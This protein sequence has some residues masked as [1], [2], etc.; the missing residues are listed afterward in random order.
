MKV[1][2]FQRYHS[3]ENVATANTM[4]LLN[5]LYHYSSDK[6][7]RLLKS[8][9]LT[10]N[11]EPEI[12]FNIQEKGARSVP[13][14]A[15]TQKSFKILIE[16]KRGNKFDVNQLINHLSCFNNEDDKILIT[17]S[18]R[19]MDKDVKTKFEDELVKN[20]NVNHINTTFEKLI[21]AIQNNIDDIDYEMQEVLDDYLDY[22]LHD[23]LIVG[24]DSWKFMRVQRAGTTF[25]FNVKN[26]VYYD[27]ADHGFR[28]HDYL[29]LYNKKSVR[30]VGKIIT[31][32]TAICI[33]N[34]I[35]YEEEYG[36]LTDMMKE[37]IN[38]AM[39]DSKKYGYD[40]KNYKHRYFFVDKFYKTNFIKST[41]R[42]PM[43]TRMFDLTEYMQ[44]DKKTPTEEIAK[45]LEEKKWK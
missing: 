34:E 15:I 22:C 37:K 30:V 36:E 21:D 29:G 16:T 27:N 26:N 12:E 18:T 7:F 9:Y 11:F 23:K 39:N 3:Q 4:L 8:E 13:D 28:H 42:A 32:A 20:G 24:H 25:D 1:H 31:Y 40:L 43:G 44:I 19:E 10:D 35:Q 2:Y 41:L 6:F 33:N 38:D 45:E 5:R 17:L 14:A